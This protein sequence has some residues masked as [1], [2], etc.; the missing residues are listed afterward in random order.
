MQPGRSSAC[1]REMRQ[2]RLASLTSSTGATERPG[3]RCG[4]CSYA[5]G[6]G[7][8]EC[9]GRT[10]RGHLGGAQ[11]MLPAL[12]VA[13]PPWKT[14]PEEIAIDAFHHVVYVTV[15]TAGF[16]ALQRNST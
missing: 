14:P 16:V 3:A 4:D 2:A 1:S 12:D 8:G 15:T 7:G 6:L 13:P 9:D 11:V 10:L 5:G